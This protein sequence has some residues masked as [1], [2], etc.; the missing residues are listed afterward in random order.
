MADIT[1]CIDHHCPSR[2]RCYRYTATAG[3]MQSYAE[4]E[5]K[6]KALNCNYFWDNAGRKK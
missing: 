4:F 1:M 2:E 6:P 3:K 5:R